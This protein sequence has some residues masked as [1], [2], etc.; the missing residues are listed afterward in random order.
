[1]AF[2]RIVISVPESRVSEIKEAA[3][4]QSVPSW[5]AALV[6]RRLLD[7][8][9]DRLWDEWIAKAEATA[10]PEDLEWVEEAVAELRQ[11][12]AEQE[13]Q[14]RKNASPWE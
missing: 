4:E 2:K 13:Q 11:F 5:F 10:T 1:M 8:E 3:G 14:S 9:S 7:Q 6:A 12:D